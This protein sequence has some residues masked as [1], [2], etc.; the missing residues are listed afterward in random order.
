MSRG[1]PVKITDLMW[2]VAKRQWVS[3]AEMVKEM[4]ADGGLARLAHEV[5]HKSPDL[6]RCHE[7]GF[8]FAHTTL[9]HLLSHDKPEAGSPENDFIAYEWVWWWVSAAMKGK[10]EVDVRAGVPGV[11][12]KTALQNACLQKNEEAMCALLEAGASSF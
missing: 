5:C 11:G 12:G 1:L 8:E 3:A 10:V 9:L 4:M 7:M 6:D 2:V